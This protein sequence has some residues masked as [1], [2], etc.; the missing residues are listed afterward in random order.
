MGLRVGYWKGNFGATWGPAGGLR[1][2][3]RAGGRRGK[4]KSR[5]RKD[6]APRGKKQQQAGKK[7]KHGRK[8]YLI[9]G[10]AAAGATALLLA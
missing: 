4:K 9:F 1:V 8:R 2:Y 5:P 6:R 3:G 10:A 7:R